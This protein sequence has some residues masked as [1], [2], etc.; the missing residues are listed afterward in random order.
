ML[1]PE[2]IVTVTADPTVV[3]VVP[4]AEIDAVNVLPDRTSFTQ[5]GA[6]MPVC[7]PPSAAE[8]PVVDRYSNFAPLEGVIYKPA[9]ADPAAR[10]SRIMTPALAETWVFS[11]E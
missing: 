6:A 11:T 4:L 10:V 9:Y 7:D 1:T 8:P 5:Y 2:P 3:Q